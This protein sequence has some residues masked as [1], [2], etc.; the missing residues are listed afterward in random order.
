MIIDFH[1]H[2]FP[3]KIAEKTISYL[4][5]KGGIPSFSNGTASLLISKMEEAGVDI[6]VALPAMTS[7]KQFDSINRFALKINKEYA[8]KKRKIIS[9]GGIHPDC[10]DIKGKMKFIKDSGFLG[11]K[12]HPD[13][14]GTFINDEKY[15]RILE[16]AKEYDLIVV[17]HAGFDCGFKGE[18]IKCTPSLV[19][20][21][22]KKVRHSKF[23]LAHLGGNELLEESLSTVCGL[24]IYLDTAYVLNTTN[25]NVFKEFIKRHGENKILFA[26]DTPWSDIK[27]NVEKFK[28]FGLDKNT[29]N[30]ILNENA[31]KLLK[32]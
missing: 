10:E 12:I 18:P 13:Y 6:S 4:M 15:I 5:E 2:I 16:Y 3:D 9:F 19:K 31:K 28:S 26:S 7:P 8:D 32:L 21:V 1:T 22:I 11:I 25:K 27:N 30:K 17:T 23:V 24:D 29:E 14:Q 20:D